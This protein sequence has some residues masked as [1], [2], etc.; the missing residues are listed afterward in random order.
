M[1]NA[2]F[3]SPVAR[4]GPLN[5]ATAPVPRVR[6]PVSNRPAVPPF[7]RCSPANSVTGRLIV[8]AFA[9]LLTM[10]PSCTSEIA[11]P[12]SVNVPADA[13]KPMPPNDVPAAKSLLGVRRVVPLNVRRSS[14]A[15]A[16]SLSQL[17][18]VVQL[19]FA[20]PPS[21]DCSAASTCA[22]TSDAKA[23]DA[24]TAEVLRVF[25]ALLPQT[26]LRVQ[27]EAAL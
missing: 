11:F 22:P 26:G 9:E 7:I 2:L 25:I 13:S 15:G 17:A 10:C 5:R 19:S 1:P 18:G 24:N 4:T 14:G 8:C 16:A 6:P 21:Q 3:D 12:P 20:P 23:A 27:R